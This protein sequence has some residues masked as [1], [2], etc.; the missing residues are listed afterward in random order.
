VTVQSPA[1]SETVLRA[2]LYDCIRLDAGAADADELKRRIAEVGWE[3]LLAEAEWPRLTSVLVRAITRLGLAPPIPAMTL[4]DGRMTIT[5]L[6]AEREADHLGR[7]SAMRD[8]L[9]EI[10]AVFEREGI[11]AVVLKGGRSVVTG[12][13]DW[14]S[15]RDLDL[16]VP[17]QLAQK[18]QET[19][20][21]MGYRQS[22]DPRPRLVHHHLHELYRDDMPGWI[23][24]HRRAGQSRV[25]ALIPTGELLAAATGGRIGVLPQHLHVLYGMVHHHIGHRAVKR[26][27]ISAKGLYEFAA[28]IAALSDDE[29]AALLERARRHP[30]LLAVLELWIAAANERYGLPRGIPLV[31][32]DDAVRWWQ[33]VRDDQPAARGISLELK[34]ATDGARMRRAVGGDRRGRRLYWWLTVPLS[35]VK[36]PALLMRVAPPEPEP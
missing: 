3:A 22:G 26:A 8:R 1:G 13:P 15:L 4:P 35:F 16:L 34:A 36:Q 31:A 14:R 23:E 24:I 28:E 29:G 27:A 5:K 11:S 17:P 32:A 6:L 10:E 2:L 18:A 19:L 25:E 12:A 33:A 21:G 30:R 9:N 7:R 20:V